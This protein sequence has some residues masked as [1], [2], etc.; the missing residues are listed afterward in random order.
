MSLFSKIKSKV[1]STKF[2][3]RTIAAGFALTIASIAA[4]AT[5]SGAAAAPTTTPD[6]DANAAIWCGITQ[7]GTSVSSEI[8]Q[9]KK[10]YANGDGHNKY[11]TIQD[12][13]NYFGISTSMVNGLSTSNVV[14]GYVSG[15]AEGDVYATI[16]G[17]STLVA[18]GAITAGRQNLSGSNPVKYGQTTFYTRPTHVSFQ[19]GQL[20][21]LIVMK[22]GVFQNAMLVSCGNPV[23]A[24]PKKPSYSI[25]KQVSTAANGTYGSNVSVNSGSAVYY[26][27]AVK[28]TGAIPVDNV[29]V[30]DT[31]PS[32][33]VYTS[34]TLQEN[35]KAVS[36]SDASKFFSSTGL[37]VGTVNNGATDTFTFTAKAGTVAF[38]D[39]SCKPGD[40]LTNNG[41]V[42]APGLSTL[43]ANAKVSTTCAPSASL[44]CTNL[45]AVAGAPDATTGSQL[46]TFT[47]K[48]SPQNVTITGY[49]F[50]F[51]GTNT[52]TIKSSDASVQTTHTYAPG[53][54]TANFTVTGTAA[55]TSKTYTSSACAFS[56]KVQ[57]A[58][59]PNYAILKQV[60]TSANGTFSS[61]VQVQSGATV[62]Y[63]IT[64]SS[65]GDAPITNVNVKDTLPSDIKYTTA[66]LQQDGT[67]V[68]A[69][70]TSS[71][72]GNGLVVPSIANGK[73]T[74]FTYSAVAGNTATD[75][76]P[77][78]KA[79]TL[80]NTGF[81]SMTGLSS[82][83]STA[84]VKT[85]C[86]QLQCLPGVQ[87]GSNE[88]YSYTCNIA[89][90]AIDN[91]NKKVTVKVTGTSTSPTVATPGNV[92]INWGD[93][94]TATVAYADVNAA[95][96]GQGHTFA[97]NSTITASIQ[98]TTPDGSTPV[99][100]SNCSV[101]VSFT[102]TTTPP[103]VMPNTGAGDV[104]GIFTGTVVTATVAARLFLARKMARR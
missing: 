98:F 88:C 80:D 26:K 89:Q 4:L 40:N 16:N 74:V 60:S 86:T 53:N 15:N 44:A 6:C 85:G 42:A 50:N 55:A 49:S 100:S 11:Y 94:T 19:N 39:A 9:V 93:G 12:M 92:T 28:S 78:C 56:I 2:K 58:P 103:P 81:M 7:N 91:A 36:S 87:A 102:T 35:G 82:Q 3:A 14:S 71:F 90:G 31:L 70:D 20:A 22:N 101:P 79:E 99:T 32:G 10:L 72:F 104:I 64:V 57:Q 24:T 45:T 47:A 73:S 75:T 67:A 25:T 65:T 48:A 59:N 17:K 21:A 23:K 97:N 38:D 13:Y 41:Y 63:K 27:I 83:Q 30:H 96:Q 52:A 77:S 51:D 46:Y 54:Y 69:T 5:M 62:Y 61:D 33:I 95:S 37:N 84:E 43:N 34:G 18:T 8:A 76:D 66:T 29:T 68:S 1:S